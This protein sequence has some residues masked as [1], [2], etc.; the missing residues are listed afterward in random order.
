MRGI[1]FAFVKEIAMQNAGRR[2]QQKKKKKNSISIE[3]RFNISIINN[4]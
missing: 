4:Y 1:V 2:R 3:R